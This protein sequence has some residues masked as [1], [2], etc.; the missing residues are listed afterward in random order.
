MAI[1][2]S[3]RILLGMQKA[4]ASKSLANGIP[5]DPYSIKVA[6]GFSIKVRESDYGPMINAER[7][8]KVDELDQVVQVI[9]D[10]STKYPG[11]HISYSVVEDVESGEDVKN[12]VMRCAIL[13]HQKLGA[14]GTFKDLVRE[15]DWDA[16]YAFGFQMADKGEAPEDVK[17]SLEALVKEQSLLQYQ[18]AIEKRL[19]PKPAQ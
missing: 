13:A 17:S 7:V 18:Q 3:I 15:S 1:V 14:K 9:K 6:D 4:L 11:H 10:L 12:T 19:A 2:Q 16:Q 8:F 5:F